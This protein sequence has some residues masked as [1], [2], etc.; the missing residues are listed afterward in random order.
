MQKVSWIFGILAMVLFF[1]F[2]CAKGVLP[3]DSN[4]PWPFAD[5]TDDPSF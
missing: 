5:I 1:N 4:Q 2:G 3:T